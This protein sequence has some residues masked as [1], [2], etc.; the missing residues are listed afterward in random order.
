MENTILETTINGSK[1]TIKKRSNKLYDNT[2][3]YVMD[4]S[5]PKLPTVIF[6]CTTERKAKNF[7]NKVQ[8]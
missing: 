7:L 4:F 2:F 5:Y 6:R 3:Y 1:Y 8:G